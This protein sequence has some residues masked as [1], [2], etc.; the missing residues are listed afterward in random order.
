MPNSVVNILRYRGQ[1]FEILQQTV[2]TQTAVMTIAPGRD[3]GPEETHAADQIVYVIEGEAVV[4]I[5]GAEH[6]AEVGACALIPAGARHHVR[7]PGTQPLFF[8][9]VYAPPAY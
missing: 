6:H 4:T 7:N 5:E 2:R 9:T 1:F 8:L 3:G